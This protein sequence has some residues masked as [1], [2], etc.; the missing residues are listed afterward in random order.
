MH[1]SV[2]HVQEDGWLRWNRIIKGRPYNAISSVTSGEATIP[3]VAGVQRDMR[4]SVLLTAALLILLVDS[5]FA[6]DG[7]TCDCGISPDKPTVCSTETQMS[8]R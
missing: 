7:L 1:L 6:Q 8:H 2:V 5:G 3:P 4:P